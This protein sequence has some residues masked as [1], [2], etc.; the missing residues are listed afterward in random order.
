MNEIPEVK[1]KIVE[2][3][4]N[5][6]TL[7]QA[8]TFFKRE[9]KLRK[10]RIS[11]EEKKSLL[12]S[13][14]NKTQREVAREL[15]RLSPEAVL[16]DRERQLSN[17]KVQIQFTADQ[18]IMQKFRRL[19][20]LLSHSTS[21]NPDYAELLHKICDIALLKVDPLRKDLKKGPR[22][23]VELNLKKSGTASVSLSLKNDR[24]GINLNTVGGTASCRNTAVLN[25]NTVR[26]TAYRNTADKSACLQSGN[27]AHNMQKLFHTRYIP[28][29]VKREAWRRGQSEC[30]Y[31]DPKTNRRC[32]SRY[33][34]EIDHI[35]P[36]GKGGKA[37]TENLTLAC[38]AHN[39]LAAVQQFGIQKMAPF[40]RHFT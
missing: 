2:G 9:A 1:D 20:E 36:F 24:A 29:A 39:Q 26:G 35:I 19:R 3:V 31:V 4:F 16:F 10:K 6:A 23:P 17:D 21:P 18:N 27:L 38:R 32:G 25:S 13:L 7:T 14:E 11:L 33:G 12:T 5:L 34:L 37:V 40:L 8:Q 28:I 22:D 30:T 15:A